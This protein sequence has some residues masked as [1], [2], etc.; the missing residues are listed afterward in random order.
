VRGGSTSS[1]APLELPRRRLALSIL[2]PTGTEPGEFE[3]QISQ[4]QETPILT[5]SGPAVLRDQIAV[6]EVR[7]DLSA[8][9]P[10]SYLLAIRGRGWDWNYYHVL[11][12]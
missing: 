5:A 11:I 7:L 12:T 8:L 3:V 6:L 9:R 2:L 10:G 4:Q 1:N